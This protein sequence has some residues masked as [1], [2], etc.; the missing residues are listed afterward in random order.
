MSTRLQSTLAMHVAQCVYFGAVRGTAA[1][2]MVRTSSAAQ[3][4]ASWLMIIALSA[5]PTLQHGIRITD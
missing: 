3:V 4:P 1:G 2:G 5:R